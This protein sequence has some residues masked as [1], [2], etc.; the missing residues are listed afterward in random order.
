MY[1]LLIDAVDVGK[2]STIRPSEMRDSGNIASVYLDSLPNLEN[3]HERLHRNDFASVVRM[4]WYGER[5]PRNGDKQIFVE[6]KVHRASYTGQSSIKE[7]GEILQKDADAFLAG[8]YSPEKGSSDGEFLGQV[9]HEIK[10]SGQMPLM[11]TSY[12]RTAFQ[13]STD[14]IVRISLD[15]NLSMTKEFPN[16]GPYW[17]RDL[18]SE[19]LHEDEVV[20][21]PYGV[22]EIKLQS[23]PPEWVKNLIR[24]GIL[25]SV[26]KFSKFLHGTG[27]LYQEN[28]D[29][30]PY[31]FLPDS[32]D[33]TKL[34]PATWDE[35]ADQEDAYAKDAADW[36]FPQGFEEPIQHQRRLSLLPFFKPKATKD[37]PVERIEAGSITIKEGLD[38][39]CD[40]SGDRNW[41]DDEIIQDHGLA[42]HQPTN[43]EVRQ[44]SERKTWPIYQGYVNGEPMSTEHKD[45]QSPMPDQV[46]RATTLVNLPLH[47]QSD[48]IHD[49][50]SGT[51]MQT[52][53]GKMIADNITPTSKL[54][55]GKVHP[56]PSHYSVMQYTLSYSDKD[57]QS[58][59]SDVKAQAPPTRTKSL[60]RT[61]VEPKTFFANERTFLQWLNISVLVMFLA[62]SLLSG[63]SLI[64]GT[65]SSISSSCNVDDSKCIAGKMSGAIIAPVALAFMAYALYMYKK[66]TI[67]ILRRETVRYDDQ[68]GPVVLV[69]IL[70]LVM[71]ISYIL[72]MIYV[73]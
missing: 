37:L 47:V 22:V 70:L 3:Y 11:R 65:G 46:S 49:L 18:M 69:V 43:V 48:H 62:L 9:M 73:F 30:V 35:M 66:R 33:T 27:F 28:A 4:R 58:S 17:C 19:P 14:N 34:T 26:P 1:G 44:S 10:E 6:R 23:A 63:S 25:L 57:S 36:L 42:V 41:C 45:S 61:R 67:Q 39:L 52:D 51:P 55:A 71:A 59:G 72:T 40:E 68:R 12:S 64:P 15:T 56:D 8:K 5:D 29:N 60:V 50:E 24:S 13:R 21:F 20:N 31:W 2:L 53:H 38:E 16:T 7:R 54:C 32:D